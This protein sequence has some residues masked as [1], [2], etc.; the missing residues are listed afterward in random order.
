MDLSVSDVFTVTVNFVF[1]E[2]HS[3]VYDEMKKKGYVE[4]IDVLT[5]TLV[6]KEEALAI[7]ERHLAS[8]QEAVRLHNEDKQVT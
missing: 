2:S 5:A 4:K 1:Q 6:Q 8:L 7:S 3:L